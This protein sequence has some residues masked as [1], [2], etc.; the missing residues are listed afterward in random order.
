MKRTGF[1]GG[2]DL[3]N[4]MNGNWNELWQ[5]KTGRKEPEDLSKQFNVALGTE[6]EAFNLNWLHQQTGWYSHTPEPKRKVISGVP[7][8]A[9]PDGIAMHDGNDGHAI[10]ECK[11]TSSYKSMD[12]IIS[13]YL[14]QVH[15][16]MRVFELD[17][18]VFSVIF[19]NQWDYTTVDYNHE[20]WMK[21]STEAYQFWQMVETDTEPHHDEQQPIDWSS[22][23]INGLVAR[24]AS[25]D[26]HFVDLAHRFVNSSQAAREHESIKK[27]LRST[28]K[29]TEREVFCDVLSIKRDKRGACRISVK[30]G[31]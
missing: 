9:R 31:E 13:T 14:P 7:Y 2:S 6:T 16:Y 30:N 25:S 11:H 4:I 1:I 26:N 15:L 27:E 12:N 19:G 22:V 29:D 24:D 23:A 3:Y 18:A 5:I 20:Y 28:I 21:V 17:K 10:V 8:Q